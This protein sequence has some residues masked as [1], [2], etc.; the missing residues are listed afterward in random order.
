MADESHARGQEEQERACAQTF[1][2]WLGS[3]RGV[4][5][6]L[7]RAEQVPELR[8]RWDYVAN[9]TGDA[10][11]LALEIKGLVIP[12]SR[13]QYGDWSRFSTW[14]TKELRTSGQVKGEFAISISI[15]WTFNQK[16][17]KLL[18]HAFVEALV[19]VGPN[20]KMGDLVNIGPEVASAFMDWPTKPPTHDHNLW[21]EH[22]IWKVINPPE[23]LHV[24][25]L[26]ESNGVSVELGISVGQAFDVDPSLQQAIQGIF[27]PNEV[28]AA[29]PNE[30]LGE[31]RQK[32]ASETFL[33]LDSHIRYNP[34][35]VSESSNRIDRT[36]LSN[37]DGVYFVS[38]SGKQV[39]KVWPY[40]KR[41]LSTRP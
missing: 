10:D 33:I 37:I 11:W 32:G 19:Q 6:E 35:V 12:R 39:S 9:I 4:D 2:T 26:D 18:V 41:A 14:A 30:Q 8:G 13:R 25:K 16:Q 3:Q 1:L 27:A 31:A 40:E 22:R 24:V 23:D 28:G 29:K 5:Y 15:P 17:G 34:A 21:L 20:V 7:L 38:V 36:L